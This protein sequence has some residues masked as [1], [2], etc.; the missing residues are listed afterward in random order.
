MVTSGAACSCDQKR[1]LEKRSHLCNGHVCV[2]VLGWGGAGGRREPGT[3]SWSACQANARNL[4]FA[5]GKVKVNEEGVKVTY[6]VSSFI[7]KESYNCCVENNTLP[8][9]GF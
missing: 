4:G 6:V 3:R 5:A 1:I 9:T 7:L 8:S 2:R